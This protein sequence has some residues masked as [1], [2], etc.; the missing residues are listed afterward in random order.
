M[1]TPYKTQITTPYTLNYDAAL[2][3]ISDEFYQMGYPNGRE[4][5]GW[6]SRIIRK[7]LNEKKPIKRITDDVLDAFFGKY[8]NFVDILDT[9]EF[10]QYAKSKGK[11][12]ADYEYK[13]FGASTAA[14]Y[15]FVSVVEDYI[16]LRDGKVVDWENEA[17]LMP[18]NVF[19][20]TKD[21]A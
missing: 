20:K 18:C 17:G 3:V 21:I 16:N 19:L 6:Y 13:A 8:K 4:R 12:P 5:A 11:K 14:D 10:P 9:P 1:R 15:R 7:G 2:A